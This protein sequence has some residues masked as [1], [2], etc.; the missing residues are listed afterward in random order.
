MTFLS[1]VSWYARKAKM[2]RKKKL[3]EN[4]SLY[5][6]ALECKEALSKTVREL[7]DKNDKLIRDIELG[8]YYKSCLAPQIAIKK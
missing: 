5:L 8:K 7:I 4:K 6:R 3:I 2:D 1:W